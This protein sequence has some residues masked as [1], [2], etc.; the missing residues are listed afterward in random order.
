M[1][2]LL[3]TSDLP[4][5]DIKHGGG[6]LTFNLVKHLSR[7]HRLSLLSF[8]REEE[9]PYLATLHRYFE[10]VNTIP[11]LRGWLSRLRRLP[12]L[13]TR[14]Y[15][16]VATFAPQ[17]AFHLR[18]M[19]FRHKYDLIQFEY[20][21]MGQYISLIPDSA[22]RVLV[23]QD[24]PSPVLRQ[25]VRIASG[26]KKYFY[27]REWNL[28]RK[29]E[30]LYSINA[31]NVFVF[32]SKDKRI[33]E[34]WDVGVNIHVTPPLLSEYFFR[35]SE[36][37]IQ[38]G[39]ILF[40]GAMHRPVNQD[41]VTILKNDIFPRVI[42]HYP[43]ARCLVVGHNPPRSIKKLAAPNF[44]ITGSVNNIE[45]YLSQAAVLVA[46]L[47]V[48]GGIVVKILQAMASGRPVVTSRAANAGIGAREESEIL[49]ADFPADFAEKVL[50]LLENPE[51]ARKIGKAARQFIERKFDPGKV[52]K[53]L[54]RI[55]EKVIGK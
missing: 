40:L 44:I 42:R 50:Q 21:H 52:E 16:V 35:I 27:Y 25:Q 36:N 30:K 55:Y 5:E 13:L 17:M 7:S 22:A 19:F 37:N 54:D 47:R 18:D 15:S 14:P 29:Q 28:S 53:K 24:I 8:V 46:P 23:L 39:T 3:V 33:A 43:A 11:A 31:G 34:S 38:P 41:A 49:V 4:Y 20:F 26:L 45:P 1:K 2:I 9:K 32:S 6:Q 51:R 48:A 12:L 10:E